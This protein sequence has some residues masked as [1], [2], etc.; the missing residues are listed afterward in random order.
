MVK[1]VIG[2]VWK[3][4]QFPGSTLTNR[5]Y[6]VSS[7][8]RV[9]SFTKDIKDRKLLTGSLTSGYRSLNL[10]I[11]GGNYTIYIHRE[12]AKEFCKKPSPKHKF[13]IHLNH[14]KIDNRCNNLEWATLEKVSS[15]QQFSPQKIAFKKR[16]AELRKGLKLDVRKVKAIKKLLDNSKSNLTVKKIATKYKVSQMTIY[17]IKNSENWK[18]LK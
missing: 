15:H 7:L 11:Q 3:P 17:R 5:K 10:H 1:K 2:E 13:V 18:N 6:A 4:I 9:A 16:Q 12:V 8:G 14:K